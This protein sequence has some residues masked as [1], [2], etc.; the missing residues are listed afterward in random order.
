MTDFFLFNGKIS[1]IS[2]FNANE[3]FLKT[4]FPVPVE[5]WFDNGNIR[6][7]ETHLENLVSILKYFN[8]PPAFDLPKQA[9]LSR[10]L[11]RS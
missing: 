10:L 9:E 4:G 3:L 5:M 6:Y 2:D 1:G 7:F 11:K 8:R